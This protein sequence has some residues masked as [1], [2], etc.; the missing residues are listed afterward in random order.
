MTADITLYGY[1][2]SPF[3]RKVS[4]HLHYKGLPFDFV[5]VSPV[6]PD[7]TI[8]F[9]GGTQVP[10]LKISDEWRR[11]SSKIGH[12]LDELCPEKPLVST[13]RAERDKILEIDDWASDQFIPGMIFRAAVDRE[14]DDAFRK[15]A[16]RLAEIVSDGATL[17]EEIKK[18]WP[19]LLGQAP[20]IVNMVN[21]LDR[22]EPLE[23]MQ[24]RLF[25]ELTQHLGDGPYLGGL[26]DP[27]LADFAIYPQMMF[28]YQVGLMNTLPVLEHPTVGPWLE[29]VA[30]HLPQNPWSVSEKFIANP[31]PF[32]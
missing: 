16:W 31:W 24:M 5:G 2:T 22:S 23:A 7:K 15:R 29:R 9:S 21:Q 27:S 13:N 6:E 19:E 14:V 3:V 25:F 4:C 32:N 26:P 11:D 30:G 10:V 20:F 28:P 8:G 17:P 1:T 12:W 18:A